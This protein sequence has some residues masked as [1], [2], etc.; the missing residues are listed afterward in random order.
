[1]FKLTLICLN[2]LFFSSLNAQTNGNVEIA[3]VINLI[4]K[5]SVINYITRLENFETRFMLA[6][7]RFL[8]AQWLKDEFEKVGFTNVELDTFE[9]KTT[10]S[11]PPRG[12]YIDTTTVQV[13]VIAT[14]PGTET[15]ND[16]YI[17]CG[18]YDCFADNANQFLYAPGADDNASGTTAVLESARVI[19]TAGYKPKSTL[20]FIAFAAEEL[21]NF[22]GGGSTHYSLMAA[23]RGD[24]IKLVI[25][26]DMIGNSSPN[27][28]F[29]TVNV[30]HRDYN[31][32][33]S[34]AYYVTA[35]SNMQIN[36]DSYSGGDLLGFFDNGYEGVYFEENVWNNSNYHKTSD[37]ILNL[38]TNYC[39]EVIKA[40]CAT[41]L[42]MQL[43]PSAIDEIQIPSGYALKQNYPNPFNPSTRILYQLPEAGYVSIK[44]YDCLGREISRLVNDFQHAG[45]YDVRFSAG[46]ELSSGMYI[47]TINCNGWSE[48]NKM[49]LVR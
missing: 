5:D 17:I 48:S 14:L 47:Y 44:V 12:R 15:P 18:H 11:L 37:T 30:G 39:T 21:I 25:N 19:M 7:N 32:I 43:C 9:C 10:I 42:G 49:M 27:A 3:D 45:I 35:Y 4:S 23:E 6:P 24:N 33:G 2:L 26:N 1:M 36:T 40:S 8:I 34:V 29:E 13:N 38:Y 20:R 22:G 28:L 46:K 41:L 31:R 16:I